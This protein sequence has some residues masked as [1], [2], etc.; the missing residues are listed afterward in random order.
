MIGIAEVMVDSYCQTNGSDPF[1][2]FDPQEYPAITAMASDPELR[3]FVGNCSVTHEVS[4]A[5][6]RA[7]QFR[8]DPL[9][10]VRYVVPPPPGARRTVVIGNNAITNAWIRYQC[11]AGR[12]EIMRE[13]P[14]DME[15]PYTR[16][17]E[18]G[19][20]FSCEQCRGSEPSYYWVYNSSTGRYEEMR[21]S[22][23]LAAGRTG[24]GA[25]C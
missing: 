8:N 21:T 7:D 11:P 5:A 12:V 2:L 17:D 1:A 20:K 18:E 3:A 25:R 23:M 9:Y 15:Q 19:A 16:P 10:S 13:N 4:I 24:Y 22:V 6:T 14:S